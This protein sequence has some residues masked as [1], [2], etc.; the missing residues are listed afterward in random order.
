MTRS[1][2][3]TIPAQSSKIETRIFSRPNGV[4]SVITQT[5]ISNIEPN[6]QIKTKSKWKMKN[7]WHVC[8]GSYT[9]RKVEIRIFFQFDLDFDSIGI[10]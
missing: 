6:T 3:K 10:R 7:K 8:L 5:L 2:D 9:Q 4:Q 1:D